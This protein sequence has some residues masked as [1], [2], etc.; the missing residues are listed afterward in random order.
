MFRLGRTDREKKKQTA[1][2]LESIEKRQKS[3][4]FAIQNEVLLKATRLTQ[5]Q[6]VLAAIT[7][8]SLK[9]PW[10]YYEDGKYC[11]SQKKWQEAKVNFTHYRNYVE[12][13]KTPVMTETNL[14]GIKKP[15]EDNHLKY[16]MIVQDNLSEAVS[17]DP[18]LSVVSTAK[19]NVY[20]RQ[21]EQWQADHMQKKK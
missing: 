15:S 21:W 9:K 4:S 20:R 14:N 17:Q 8:L 18:L 11:I 5:Q 12:E 16:L 1:D 19:S 3:L 10:E 7:R 13:K 2:L 6:D